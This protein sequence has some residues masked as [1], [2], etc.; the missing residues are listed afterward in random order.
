MGAVASAVQSVGDVVTGAVESVVNTATD[1]VS[2]VGDVVEDAGDFIVEDVL[3]PVVQTV[4]KTI[5]A[6]MEDPIGTAVK[7]YAYST[8]NPL[9]I[10]AATTTVA[11]A[12]GADMDRALESGAKGY[13]AA[14]IGQNVG[15]YVAPEAAE[16]FGPE[17]VPA[18]RATTS[19]AANVSSAVA[20]GQDPVAALIGSGINSS[21]SE[22][23]KTIPGFDQL[24]KSQQRAAVSAIATT[25]QGRDPTPALLNEALASGIDAAVKSY[26]STPSYNPN[27]GYHDPVYDPPA[28]VDELNQQLFPDAGQEFVPAETSPV[29]PQPS[30]SDLY[31]STLPPFTDQPSLESP[32][33]AGPQEAPTEE[34]TVEQTPSLDEVK[35]VAKREE[36]EPSDPFAQPYNE[37]FMRDYYESIGIDPSSLTPATPMED[38]PLAYLDPVKS[39]GMSAGQIFKSL[40]P[41]G[42]I[43]SFDTSSITPFLQNAAAIGIPALAIDSLLDEN[44]NPRSL[45]EIEAS[46]FNWNPAAWQAPE[47]AAAY[48]QAQLNPTYAA[49]GGLMSLARG[50]I[51]TLGGYSDGGRLLKGPGDGMSDHIPAVIGAKQPARL[52]DGEFVIPADVVS[53][54]GNGSTEAGA[55]VLYKM[56]KKV[57]RARTGNSKQGKQINPKKFIPS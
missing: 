24:S 18:A 45:G 52:A 9:L 51:A 29:S 19:A 3:E 39:S 33:S 16:Y 40:I 36:D 30:I 41:G 35:V 1:V 38:D 56:M 42:S 5:E 11:L 48:G 8:G 53:H 54:L 2:S 34:P 28:T 15:E 57:R 7:V 13:V 50:G 4:E 17:Y 46:A 32:T 27:A 6:A 26:E 12:N 25:L 21:A 55:N 20:L 44:G 22:I 47:D 43:P 14:Q 49:Q 37:Q 23:A 31:E 10:A